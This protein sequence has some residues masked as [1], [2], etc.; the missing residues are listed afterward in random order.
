MAE[1][2]VYYVVSP[3]HVHNVGLLAPHLDEYSLRIV[4]ERESPWLNH[5]NMR[6]LPFETLAFSA[7]DIP[8]NL[9]RDEVRAV[10]FSTV[11]PRYGPVVLLAAAL[12]R[13]IPTVAIEESNQIALN[14]GSVNNYLLPVDHILVASDCERRGMIESG[15]PDRRFAVTGWPFYSGRTEKTP[16]AEKADNRKALGL[17]PDRPVVALALTSLHNAGESP[18]VRK[19]QLL[20][21]SRGLPDGFQLAIK[22]HPVEKRE[23][24]QSFV[25]EYA[26]GAVIVESKTRIE[27]LLAAS[28]I[29]LNRGISQVCFEALLQKVP[30]LVLEV[31]HRTP[32]HDMVPELVAKNE[33][34]LL[35]LIGKMY[36][37][38]DAM[39]YY[40]PLLTEHF[41]HPPVE[42]RELTCKRIVSIA[43]TGDRDPEKGRQ[44]FDLALFQ[45]WLGKEN[46]A[47]VMVRRAAG[48]SADC[49]VEPFVALVEFRAERAD[50][51]VLEQCVGPGFHVHLLQSLWVRQLVEQSRRPAEE[52][53]RWMESFPARNQ[54]IWFLPTAKAWVYYL[55]DAGY[56][57]L[58]KAFA[59]RLYRDFSYI[60]HFGKLQ[61]E[62]ELYLSG[63]YGRTRVL[64]QGRIEST[65]RKGKS[66]WMRFYRRRA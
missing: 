38:D 32:F 26:P 44:W 24:L 57:D 8:E 43:A 37:S 58:A 25:D 5:A 41:P 13:G 40:G 16:V 65:L 64:L 19:R 28:D 55:A 27:Q 47:V 52:D 30:V 53:I 33:V 9:W 29:L 54:P 4:Y 31:G 1:V 35:Q 22:A 49:P 3:V 62:L 60:P 7:D 39:A 51:Q 56:G 61:A 63:F 46:E 59:G 10:V 6:E 2:I 48:G 12:A 21:S 66:S 34:D 20:F 18:A 42:A 45:A 15:F 11:Q 17:D 23:H 36:K 50:L 14:Q